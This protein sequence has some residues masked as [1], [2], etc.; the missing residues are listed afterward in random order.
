VPLDKLFAEDETLHW[1]PVVSSY[2]DGETSLSRAA[3][4][5]GEHPL[6]LRAQFVDR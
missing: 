2:I 3:E 6:E 1:S 4:L 5:L